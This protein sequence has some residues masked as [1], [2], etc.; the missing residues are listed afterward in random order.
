MSMADV[1]QSVAAYLDP[2]RPRS[3]RDVPPPP[4]AESL[5]AALRPA[6]FGG[7]VDLDRTPS[8]ERSTE[9]FISDA[10]SVSNLNG[11]A[12]SFTT[13]DDRDS[14]PLRET[15]ARVISDNDFQ[16]IVDRLYQ[17]Q[18]TYD[19]RRDRKI[20]EKDV[21]EMQGVQQ[22]PTINKRSAELT[23]SMAP[24][25]N[26]Q[27]K[28]LEERA[29]ERALLVQRAED[30]ELSHV[31]GPEI[32]PRSEKIKRTV[33]DLM[34]WNDAKLAKRKVLQG[35]KSREEVYSFQP[36]VN[37]KS[38]KIF[39]QFRQTE[40]PM[41]DRLLRENEERKAKRTLQRELGAD[42]RDTFYP[43]ISQRARRVK[44]EGRIFDRL[45][46]NARQQKRP[47]DDPDV[48]VVYRANSRAGSRSRPAEADDQSRTFER[49]FSPPPRPH[50]AGSRPQSVGTVN[51]VAYDPEFDHIFNHVRFGQ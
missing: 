19:D 8:P 21:A 45:Y 43:V 46:D 51:V 22:K 20:K 23:Q 35:Q 17:T 28:L 38:R 37:S 10:H 16:K 26:R 29:E 50:T 25:T 36:Q 12:R 32:C 44:R 1:K 48:E 27:S 31:H 11:Y 24:L 6:R 3:A 42:N 40:E 14:S 4:P 15:P 47:T 18:K 2:P 49:S 34:A 7:P 13:V 30:A 41:W 5:L 9:G 39:K 33:D